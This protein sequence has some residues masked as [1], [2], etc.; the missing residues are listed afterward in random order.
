MKH[1]QLKF[2]KGFRISIGNRKSQAAVTVL[3]VGGAEGGPDNRHRRADQWLIITEG[4]G[5]AIINGRKTALKAGS[6]VLIEAGDTH[7]I[8]NTGKGLLKTVSIYIPPAY[9][10][11]G[12]ELPAG[13]A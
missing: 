5:V 2:T 13:R 3:S 9:D 10:G 6:I 11:R 12:R 4:R 8:R 1:E 7:E